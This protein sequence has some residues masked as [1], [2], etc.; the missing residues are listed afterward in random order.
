MIGNEKPKCRWLKNVE[1]DE[2]L[3]DDNPANMK[4]LFLVQKTGRR[5]NRN[6]RRS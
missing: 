6:G 2:V 1:V 5:Q 3:I 4:K